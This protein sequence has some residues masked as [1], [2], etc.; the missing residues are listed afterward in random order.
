M[1][2]MEVQFTKNDQAFTKRIDMA[3]PA[4]IIE[5]Q[6]EIVLNMLIF[7]VEIFVSDFGVLIL[8]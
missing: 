8:V 2:I 6:D 4:N 5:K 1:D 7:C 3:E